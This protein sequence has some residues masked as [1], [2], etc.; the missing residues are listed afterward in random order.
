M[1]DY[2]KALVILDGC[3]DI[4]YKSKRK[5]LNN[6][7]GSLSLTDFATQT[8]MSFSGDIEGFDENAYISLFND[9]T[10]EKLIVEYQNK[11]VTVI[12]E[13]D[14]NYPTELY[15]LE[16]RPICLYC[17]GNV[18]LLQKDKKFSIVGSRKTLPSVL[19][20]AEDYAKRLSESGVV[21]VTGVAG[22]GDLSAIKGALESKNLICVSACGADN[23]YREYTHEFL[24]KVKKTCL[25]VSE[26]PPKVV[27]MPYFYPFRN[28]IIAGLS[29]GTLVVSGT[30]KSG[31]RYTVNY[32]LDYGKDVFSF[33]YSLGIQSGELCN[34]VIKDGGYLVTTLSDIS[35]VLGFEAGE[36]QAPSLSK[37]EQS[38]LTLIK[39]G[40]ITVDDILAEAHM[41]VFE[42][43]STLTALEIKG[44]VVKNGSG[45]YAPVK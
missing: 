10:F 31:T 19:K 44:L 20:I 43:I 21:I 37:E 15:S 35:E 28:R 14:D 42:L 2:G 38:V 9:K 6:L 1:T 7:I 36:S 13:Q 24:N 30:L 23:L 39:S 18:E 17:Q 27:A 34:S 29:C 22:G 16:D 12:T 40:K 33:P 45:E 3:F 5:A 25:I 11:G 32:A 4:D 8:A 26:Y 41:K